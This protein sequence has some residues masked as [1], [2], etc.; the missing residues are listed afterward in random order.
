MRVKILREAFI[1]DA[2]IPIHIIIINIIFVGKS[3]HKQNSTNTKKKG[4]SGIKEAYVPIYQ[5]RSENR[6]AETTSRRRNDRLPQNQPLNPT[7]SHSNRCLP[8]FLERKTKEKLEKSW[9]EGLQEKQ[10]RERETNSGRA[11]C[12]RLF[13]T[14][15]AMFSAESSSGNAIQYLLQLP[16]L[17]SGLPSRRSIGFPSSSSW[18]PSGVPV[19]LHPFCLWTLCWT[20]LSE[21]RPKGGVGKKEKRPRRRLSVSFSLDPPPPPPS[22]RLRHPLHFFQKYFDAVYSTWTLRCLWIQWLPDNRNRAAIDIFM[23]FSAVWLLERLFIFL[24][25]VSILFVDSW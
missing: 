3:Y 10:E 9:P 11:G 2:S 23:T 12:S 18:T 17:R 19:H 14:N 6:E 7:S 4:K 5:I 20:F 22:P 1:Y 24:L 15:I 21:Q 8:S 25:A 16:L 13:E